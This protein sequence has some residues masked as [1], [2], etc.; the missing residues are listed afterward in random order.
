MWKGLS[1]CACKTRVLLLS[2]RCG[3]HVGRNRTECSR[4]STYAF[5]TTK[6]YSV[7]PAPTDKDLTACLGS[8]P[9]VLG[10]NLKPALCIGG[11]SEHCGRTLRYHSTCNKKAPRVE[12]EIPTS[13]PYVKPRESN[14]GD[15]K[16]IWRTT[17]DRFIDFCLS[18]E[19][20]TRLKLCHERIIASSWSSVTAEE[21]AECLVTPEGQ[22]KA[23]QPSLLQRLRYFWRSPAHFLILIITDAYQ[24]TA[25]EG[26]AGFSF[27]LDP[28]PLV[29]IS[30]DCAIGLFLTL[31]KRG[32]I[33]RS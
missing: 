20:E 9:P 4:A 15:R 24:A 14:G 32:A 28:C 6:C 5:S 17:K 2:P 22:G 26:I 3:G 33:A 27:L 25:Q 7:S 11:S 8:T 1:L 13:G 21:V 10:A 30:S 16:F 18:P 23:M 19:E 29:V 31:R 12:S